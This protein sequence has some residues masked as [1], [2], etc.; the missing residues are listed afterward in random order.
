LYYNSTLKARYDLNCVE[1]A[2]KLQS[3]NRT[4]KRN[5]KKVTR[6]KYNYLQFSLKL[7]RATATISITT[8]GGRYCV[9]C[10]LSVYEQDK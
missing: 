5:K 2:V 7:Q 9:D 8:G 1:S 4:K 6:A 3:T 10:R